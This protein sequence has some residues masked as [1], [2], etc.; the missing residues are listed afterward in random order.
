MPGRPKFLP[1]PDRKP[2]S[3][4]LRVFGFS[5]GMLSN[6]NNYFAFL[7]DE[8]SERVQTV[9][10]PKQDCRA[11]SQ[12]DEM[13][14]SHIFQPVKRM[15]TG[16]IGINAV[17]NCER[18]CFIIALNPGMVIQFGLQTSDNGIELDTNTGTR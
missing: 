1:N 9:N 14:G 18:P 17:N 7:V 12:K 3:N 15:F 6:S 11:R 16:M 8:F 10:I 4:L 5:S 13:P 2:H